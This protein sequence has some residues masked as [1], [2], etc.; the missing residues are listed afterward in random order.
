MFGLS[1]PSL[2]SRIV[3]LVIAFS[4]HEFSHAWVAYKFGDTTAK[5]AGRLTLNPLAHLDP[6]GSI[7]LLLAGFGWAKP[8]PVNPYALQR[9]SSSAMMWVSL[10]GPASNF[11]LAV[12]GSIPFRFRWVPYLNSG[13]IFPSL[14][15]F[16]TE[17]III[18][19]MLFLFNLIPLAPLDGAAIAENLLPRAWSEALEK[20]RPYSA[21]ILIF[22][23][24]VLPRLG[25]DVLGAIIGP[26]IRNLFYLL[27]S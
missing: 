8:V 7:M 9:K 16:L 22:I 10:A 6:L 14:Y 1:I 3:I 20:I 19:L 18:N 11:L 25:I 23:A 4:V 12:L 21:Y 2:I 17:F 15:S 24:I 13:E 5:N 26:V 27:V